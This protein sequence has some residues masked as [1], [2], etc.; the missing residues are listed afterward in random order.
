M[1][2]E[3]AGAL[4]FFEIGPGWIPLGV[5]RFREIV[6]KALEKP[7]E[8]FHTLEEALNAVRERV[9]IPLQKYLNKS[10]LVNYLAKQ[11]RLKP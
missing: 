7:Y 11:Q 8:R 5:W 9:K 10:R 6:R 4:V 2:R 1:R 3:Q